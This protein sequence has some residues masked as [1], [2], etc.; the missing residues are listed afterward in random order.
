MV[1]WQLFELV[2]VISEL[3]ALTPVTTPVAETFATEGLEETQG[4][5]AAAVEPINE[6]VEPTH[7]F[8]GPEIVGKG[9]TVTTAVFWQPFELV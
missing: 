3:P 5:V 2:Y 7:T 4:V 6:I 8:I 9:F 1:F